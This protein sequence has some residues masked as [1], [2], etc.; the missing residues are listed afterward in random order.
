MAHSVSA[1][2]MHCTFVH[3]FIISVS[4]SFFFF[5]KFIISRFPELSWVHCPSFSLLPT[6]N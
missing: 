6:T 1:D 2:Q 3:K 5:N 4:L